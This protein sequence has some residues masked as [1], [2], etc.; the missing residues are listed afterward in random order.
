MPR[1]GKKEGR[2]PRGKSTDP[3]RERG[4][5]LKGTL[6][7]FITAW[8]RHIALLTFTHSRRRHFRSDKRWIGALGSNHWRVGEDAGT[9]ADSA[10]P[11]AAPYLSCVPGDQITSGV[12]LLC[13]RTNG[14]GA[15]L[16]VPDLSEGRQLRTISPRQYAEED[17]LNMVYPDGGDKSETV[18]ANLVSGLDTTPLG[19]S[20]RENPWIMNARGTLVRATSN[21]EDLINRPARRLD[22]RDGP[23][24]TIIQSS[25]PREVEARRLSEARSRRVQIECARLAQQNPPLD[26]P[27]P[28]G[29]VSAWCYRYRTVTPPRNEHLLPP[30]IRPGFVP[31]PLRIRRRAPEGTHYTGTRVEREVRLT[32]EDL[33]LGPARPPALDDRPLDDHV[34]G[35]CFGIK[36]HPV[37]YVMFAA[38]L[39][40]REE[41]GRIMIAHPDWI[42]KSKV[43]YDWAGLTFPK[44]R[45]IQVEDSP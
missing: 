2:R 26:P 1:A 37:L 16:E 11:A 20:S 45:R 25:D 24:S 41:E 13:L 42:D 23:P 33:Y 8:L 12:L 9:S 18:M 17:S 31:G 10:G 35:I 27:L 21:A 32:E 43:A 4:T 3:V 28:P 22:I 29:R 6:K 5:N 19:G 15:Q 44:R 14:I 40:D 7:G 36:S 38:P 39:Q 34:C 30:E